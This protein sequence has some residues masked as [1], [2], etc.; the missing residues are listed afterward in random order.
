MI[1]RTLFFFTLGIEFQTVHGIDVMAV[2]CSKIKY[3]QYTSFIITAVSTLELFA[4]QWT[5]GFFFFGL[6]KTTIYC[7]LE[8]SVL[9]FKNSLIF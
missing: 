2:C 4:G 3:K 6:N 8:D 7:V 9:S 5:K 1:H